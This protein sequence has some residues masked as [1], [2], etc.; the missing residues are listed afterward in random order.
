MFDTTLLVMEELLKK[1]YQEGDR[2]YLRVPERPPPTV[3]EVREKEK[4]EP[5][6]VIT[7]QL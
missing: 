5:K 1:E 2:P 3:E 7:I 4:K 6:R